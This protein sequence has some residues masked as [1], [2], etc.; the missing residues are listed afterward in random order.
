MKFNEIGKTELLFIKRQFWGFFIHT[1]YFIKLLL[2]LV[3]FTQKK[4]PSKK[5]NNNNP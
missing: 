1:P 3:V 2:L 4:S 5:K